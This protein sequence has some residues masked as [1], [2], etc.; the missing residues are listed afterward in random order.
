[1]VF[2]EVNAVIVE[3]IT[4]AN[5]KPISTFILKNHNLF[6]LRLAQRIKR[7]SLE[8][9]EVEASIPALELAFEIQFFIN[10]GER[11]DVS[12]SQFVI[13]I[14][15]TIAFEL[16]SYLPVYQ[17]LG[18]FA[19]ASSNV[20]TFFID[21]VVGDSGMVEVVDHCLCLWVYSL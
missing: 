8:S 16:I 6:L 3:S 20:V 4:N 7:S 11:Y 21:I 15:E 5:T 1:M 14:T 13:Q 9:V 2:D 10:I 18:F 12:R 19:V 17:R